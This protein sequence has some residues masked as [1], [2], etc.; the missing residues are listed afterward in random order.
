MRKLTVNEVLKGADYARLFNGAK[1]LQV[2]ERKVYEDGKKTEKTDFWEAIVIL[3]ENDGV[4]VSV[5]VDRQP[6]IED[7]T[8]MPT[9]EF[10]DLS[11]SSWV[12]DGRYIE[13]SFK[14]N[15][16]EEA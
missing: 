10:E 3:P 12:K 11:A 13:L 8:E 15:T 14:A 6:K 4:I 5:K 1:L 9:V 7:V 16:I 2:T